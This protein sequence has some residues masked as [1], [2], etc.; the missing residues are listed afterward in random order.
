VSISPA[1][2]TTI[3][4]TTATSTRTT[5]RKRRSDTRGAAA[6]LALTAWTLFAF[7]GVLHWTTVPLIAAAPL[8]AIRERQ[9]IFTAPYR[10]LDAALVLWV[11]LAAAMLVPVAAPTRLAIAPASATIDRTLL[12]STP[13]DPAAAPPRP[14]SIDPASTAWTVALGAGLVLL[15]WSARGIASSGG[16]RA[17]VRGIAWIS[18]ALT[19]A[20][21]VIHGA[22][23]RL[24]YGFIRPIGRNP[25]PFGPFV[26]RN[27]LATWLIMALPLVAGYMVARVESRRRADGAFGIASVVDATALWL[28]GSIIFMLAALL[29]AISRSGL[30]GAVA[31]ALTLLVLAR[32][33]M[34]RIGWGWVAGSAAAVVAVAASYASWQAFARRMEETLASG[35]G[36]RREIWERTW[37]MASDFWITG[38]GV[39]AYERAMT[40]YQPQPHVFYFNHAHDEYLQ[41]L[42]EGG[43][44]LGVPALCAIAASAWLIRR[45]LGAD[46]TAVFWI[47]AGAA[48]GMLAVA[49]QSVWDTGLRMPANAALFA[50]LAAIA[51]HDGRDDVRRSP[52]VMT[53]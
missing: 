3:R 39:G 23:P 53:R 43:V 22:T 14:L 11:L 27:D 35:L 45:Q 52:A 32:R 28:G 10:L 36:G 24:M 21:L 7:A 46:R 1:T 50:L 18:L 17:T 6:L 41:L 47:R 25:T 33:R 29:V 2:S 31:G 44:M 19:M 15:F 49:V 8:L 48:A 38:V 20:A 51:L 12:L 9:S 40:V 37:A 4:G 42:S 30:I 16:L 34:S 5:T 26:N 13:A